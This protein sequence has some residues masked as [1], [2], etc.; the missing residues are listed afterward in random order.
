MEPIYVRQRLRPSRYA[1][2]VNEGDIG[3]ALLAA[4]LNAALWGGIYNPIVPLAPVE[5]RN[6]LLKAF[7]PDILI[8]LAGAEPPADSAARYEYRIIAPGDLV[9]TDT[10]TGRRRLG[11][12]FNILPIIRHVHEKEVRFVMEPTRAALLIPDG[13]EGWPEFVAFAYG[14]FQWLPAM[15]ANFEDAFRH[16]LRARAI[17][18]PVLTPPPDYEDL[19]LPINFTRYGLQSWGGR[20]SF[21]S[22]IIYIADH[23]NL[24]DLIEFWNIRATGR[25]VVFVPVAASQ[26]FEPLIRFIAAEGRYPINQ[27]VENHADLQK[28]PSVTEAAF[29]EVCNWI[30]TLDLGPL[31]KRAWRPRFGLEIEFYV[32]DIHVAEIQASEGEEISILENERM[33]PVKM[34]LPP[35]LNEQDTVKGEFAWSVDISMTGG[36]LRPEWMFSFPN[37][38]SVE[39]V[40]R[41]ATIAMPSEVRL[42]RRGLVLRQDGPRS[43]LQLIPVAT[44]DVFGA[45]FRQAG[46]EAESSEPGRYAEQIIKK[47][48]SLHG[49]CRVFKIRGVRDILDYLGKG[50]TL[51][52]GNMNQIVM[53]E[54]PDRDGQK[55]WRPE[56]YSDLFLRGVQRHPPGFGIIFDILLEKQIIRPGF[57]FECRY[58][59][60]RD[61]YHV[62]EFGEEYTC[63]YCFTRQ[64]VDFASTQEWQYKADGL[65][66]I[67]DSAQGS[68]A[69]IIS[70]W[71]F[72]DLTHP[73]GRYVT[74]Q[75]LV[76]KDSGRRY[77]IDY[78]FMVTGTFDT[79][80]DLVLGQAARFGDF[81]DDEVRT[82]AEIADRFTQK[83]YLAFSTLKDRY[84]DA[85][86]E[87]LR[88]LVSRDYKV[89][90]LTREE[91]DPYFLFDR[92]K[93]TRRKHAASLED[94]AIGTIQLNMGK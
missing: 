66:Q 18:L 73:N 81:T 10:G 71:R 8:N 36:Y 77:E 17:N 75:N 69:V 76:A 80:Y 33:M 16:G 67:P 13:V 82:T 38:P 28:G 25:T 49:D 57:A 48:G 3:T 68:V 59:S 23:Q 9:R 78:A 6:G 92:F 79:S 84:S 51:T 22:H 19:V 41:R 83:P 31:A 50:T 20:A 7:D 54:L 39:A 11:F 40:V 52:K 21:S 12:G 53:S 91:L 4:S 24:T 27:Q 32:G 61:W 15:D 14:S 87:R 93:D 89:I 65:F 85:E 90:A 86:R 74:S 58:C 88:D 72:S 43:S 63:R 35:F 56:L 2:L 94:L 42:G 5:S 29:D 30:G 64:R 62:S 37:E 46:L 26:A 55:N 34:I 60:K 44:K 1:F 45:L 47:M 70:L